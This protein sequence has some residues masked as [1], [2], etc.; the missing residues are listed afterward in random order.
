TAQRNPPVDTR[1]SPSH[2][3]ANGPVGKTQAWLV[4]NY[5]I[6]TLVLCLL[7]HELQR[8]FIRKKVADEFGICRLTEH[9]IVATFGN[10]RQHKKLQRVQLRIQS[11]IPEKS[12]LVLI[13]I[14]GIGINRHIL[15]SVEDNPTS[16]KLEQAFKE[17][18]QFD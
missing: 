4:W 17:A 5:E 16:S 6:G 3:S 13:E 9:V 12:G 18:V 7:D 14:L 11:V 2:D 1:S 10:M 8:S 15:D